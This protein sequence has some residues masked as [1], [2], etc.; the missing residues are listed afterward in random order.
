MKKILTIYFFI[1]YYFIYQNLLNYKKF[2]KIVK[3]SI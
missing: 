1:F 2:E 3:I